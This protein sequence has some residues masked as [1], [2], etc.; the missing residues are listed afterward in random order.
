M[1]VCMNMSGYTYTWH[2]FFCYM[3][4]QPYS[5]NPDN[6]KKNFRLFG[7]RLFRSM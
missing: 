3:Q 6:L 1:C 5:G 4:L 7:I 2:L